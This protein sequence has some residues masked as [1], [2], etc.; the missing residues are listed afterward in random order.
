[1]E[2][3]SIYHRPDSEYAYLY[4]KDVM[5]IRI[6]TKRNDIRSVRLHYGDSVIFH[7]DSYEKVI[8]M[9][10]VASDYLFDYWQSSVEVNFS[11]IQYIFELFSYGNQ[12]VLYGDRGI[13]ENTS[14]NLNFFMNGFKLPYFHEVDRCKV[15]EWVPETIWYQI[16]PERFANGDTT[17][18]PEGSL[19]WDSSISPQNYDFFGGD[20][21]GVLDKLDY[22]QDLGITG[23][24]FCPIFE[25]PSNHKYDTLDYYE[26]DR[27]FGDKYLFKKL[28]DEAHRRGMK[29]MLDAVF[30]HIGHQSPQ[31]QD[32]IE[33][34]ERSRYKDWFHIQQFPVTKENLGNNRNLTYHAFAFQ[35]HMPKL[36]TGNPE[37]KEY[38]LDIATYWIKHFNIDAWRLDVANEIDHQFWREFHK[39]VTSVKP[40]L[41]ILGEI[42]HSSQP[43]LN[44]DEFHAVMNYPLS[45]SIKNYFLRKRQSSQKFISDI[46]T[47]SM[48]YRRQVAEAMFNLLD[49]HD[50]ER[51]LTTANGNLE[52]VKSALA[53][54]FLHLGTPCIYYGTEVGLFGEHDPDCR[55]VMPWNIED[56][57]IDLFEFVKR[58]IAIRKQYQPFIQ[59]GKLRLYQQNNLLITSYSLNDDKL[60]IFFNQTKNEQTIVC[61]NKVI[62][63]S[64]AQ[65]FDSTVILKPD[66]FLISE[67]KI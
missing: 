16:F 5:H 7:E 50:T 47:Q 30:N 11:R 32:V 28:V 42:W 64:N 61:S 29:V 9:E 3:T 44:G 33:K 2:L 10:K 23:L 19:P 63:I 54:L 40:D 14:E 27:H 46:Q 35:G 37:V 25:A 18:S 38:L 15:P 56:Q 62:E 58:L 59:Y 49:S 22:L 12:T 45:E 65:I 31:W 52:A 66:G 57:N 21:K 1:M 67:H 41:Y 55:R 43:W 51:I 17:L 39:A 36:N 34:G 53:F 48:Y 13:V 24:Y 4:T 20:L 6:R 8:E 60:E 26:I